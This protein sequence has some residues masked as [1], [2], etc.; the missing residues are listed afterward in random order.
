MALALVASLAVG[1]ALPQP[2][3]AY[4]FNGDWFTNSAIGDGNVTICFEAGTPVYTNRS[5]ISLGVQ[6]WNETVEL[7]V[8][9]TGGCDGSNDSSN[10]R[11]WW[12]DWGSG[13]TCDGAGGVSDQIAWRWLEFG[14][15]SSTDIHFNSDCDGLFHW[16]VNL[17]VPNDRYDA[18]S[19]AAHESGHAYGLAHS[20]NG[21]DNLMD[22]GGPNGNV[23]WGVRCGLSD[24]DRDG[25][26][27]RYPG[28]T[29]TGAGFP[30]DSYCQE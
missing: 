12:T 22:A 2:T 15:Y 18:Q 19:V 26:V 4:E 9:S 7:T 8:T 1:L 30:Y 14:G 10:I 25:F 6:Y 24:D 11:I 17:P 29:P 3:A 28:L 27:A 21:N 13:D 5:T 16:S 23:F 20:N